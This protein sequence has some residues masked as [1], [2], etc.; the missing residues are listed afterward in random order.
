[1]SGEPSAPPDASFQIVVLSGPAGSGKTTIVQRLLRESPVPLM[2]SVSATTRPSR[3]AEVDGRDYYFISPEEFERRRRNGEFL[4][5]A[6]VHRSG[7]WYGTLW[8]ELDRARQAG[9]W[10]LLEVDVEGALSVIERYPDALSIFL[11]TTSFDEY[12]QRL[13]ARGTEREEDI[14]RR[15]Q[16]ARQEL[17]S[18]VRYRHQVVNDDLDRAVREICDIIAQREAELHAG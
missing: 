10:I 5:Y 9:V 8:S 13:R 17:Q 18:A 6:E 15:L 7:R 12:E 16:T 3:L 4:E 14:Q 11:S 1:M 2:M